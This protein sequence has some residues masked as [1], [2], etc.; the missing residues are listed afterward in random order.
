MGSLE[1]LL[2][3]KM[4]CVRLL[5]KTVANRRATQIKAAQRMKKK[6]EE[7]EAERKSLPNLEKKAKRREDSFP[8]IYSSQMARLKL[9]FCKMVRYRIA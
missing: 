1:K 6:K 4:E 7:E 8:R 9:G 5:C 2:Q 3:R